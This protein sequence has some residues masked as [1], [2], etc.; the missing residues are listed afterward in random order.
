MPCVYIAPTYR[1]LDT[2]PF[3][4]YHKLLIVPVYLRI[5]FQ[6]NIF[7][8]VCGSHMKPGQSLLQITI[9]YHDTKSTS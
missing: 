1:E 8:V 5:V 9:V 2:L 7:K 4:L 3:L 6:R